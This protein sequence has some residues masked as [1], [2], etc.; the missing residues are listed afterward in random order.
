MIFGGG[1]AWDHWRYDSNP[2]GYGNL[3]IGTSFLDIQSNPDNFCDPATRA[4]DP[5]FGTPSGDHPLYIFSCELQN[6]V[7]YSARGTGTVHLPAYVE[8]V[9]IGIPQRS[10]DRTLFESIHG[11]WSHWSSSW[12][13]FSGEKTQARGTTEMFHGLATVKLQLNLGSFGTGES[14][15]TIESEEFD[16]QIAK[17][18]GD[19]EAKNFPS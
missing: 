8:A 13:S 14:L 6:G 10:V 3:L 16:K 19:Y 5:Q 1:W 4:R 2:A 9:L 18:L 12:F 11:R 15:V 17:T 7:S